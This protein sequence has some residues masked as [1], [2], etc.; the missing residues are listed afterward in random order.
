VQQ[1]LRVSRDTAYKRNKI[2]IRKSSRNKSDAVPINI[3]NMERNVSPN[4]FTALVSESFILSSLVWENSL[5][6][7]NTLFLF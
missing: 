1:E 6:Q 4:L 7:E 2:V 3:G 5:L